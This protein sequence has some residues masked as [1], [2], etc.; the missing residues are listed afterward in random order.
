MTA[1]R[2]SLLGIYFCRFS[3]IYAQSLSRSGSLEG[4]VFGDEFDFG[5]KVNFMKLTKTSGL[6][7]GG[8]PARVL[9]GL[10]IDI[11][12]YFC[13]LIV[14]SSR[15][16]PRSKARWVE[17]QAWWQMFYGFIVTLH[18]HQLICPRSEF[19]TLNNPSDKDNPIQADG[20]MFF[21]LC[22]FS[23]RMLG[24]FFHPSFYL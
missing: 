24:S 13:I 20:R 21:F 12:F 7:G 17:C 1:K 3:L 22:F 8:R 15:L 9:S 23:L 14:S 16:G 11:L 5:M 6:G 10:I 18:H 4:S 2:V 19:E